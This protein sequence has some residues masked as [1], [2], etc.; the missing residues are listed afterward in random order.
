[1]HWFGV[2]LQ[3]KTKK[4]CE[5]CLLCGIFPT[6]TKFV[7]LLQSG[8][9]QSPYFIISRD[10]YR[11]ERW[12][13]YQNVNP[14]LNSLSQTY[15]YICSL[16][17]LLTFT[18]D[19]NT[20]I[21][22]YIQTSL[23]IHTLPVHTYIHTPSIP[24]WGGQCEWHRMARMTGPVILCYSVNIHSYIHTYV[25][26]YNK[27]IIDPPFGGINDTFYDVCMYGHHI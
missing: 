23:Y 13:K 7:V 10:V 26:R 3:H 16:G 2:Q 12:Y 19:Y 21:H 15:L 18:F 1:M 24:S 20:Y 4:R 25:H 27:Y 17:F 5:P 6:L 8:H 11:N 22:P 9:I 14:L